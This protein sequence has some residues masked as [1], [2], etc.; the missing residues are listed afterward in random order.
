MHRNDLLK[1]LGYAA[2]AAA[3]GGCVSSRRVTP[4]ALPRI[5]VKDCEFVNTAT[6]KAFHP[7]GFNY[8]RL[9]QHPRVPTAKWHS[10]FG[11]GHYSHEEAKKMFETSSR[12]G[13]NTTRVFLS[14]F[15]F[16]PVDDGRNLNP[17]VMDNLVD[18]LALAAEYRTYVVLT[19]CYQLPSTYY[20][21][22]GKQDNNAQGWNGHYLNDRTIKNKVAYL[23]QLAQEIKDR[24]PRLLSTV[25][26]FDLD[27]EVQFTMTHEPFKSGGQFK[28]LGETYDLDQ[29][30]EI[31]KLMDVSMTNWIDLCSDAVKAVD[32]QAMVSASVFSFYNI[33]RT[34]GPG[35]AREQKSERALRD[36]RIPA[37]PVAIA[38]SK[39]DYIDL[40]TYIG[41]GTNT[42][43]EL[44]YSA[45]LYFH[46][47]EYNDLVDVCTKNGKPL[48]AGEFG[49]VKAST[50]VPEEAGRLIVQQV[51]LLAEHGFAGYLL[52]TFDGHASGAPWQKENWWPGTAQ[53][54]TILKMMSANL[55]ATP[56]TDLESVEEL[57]SYDY[58][59]DA[60]FVEP[61]GESLE[62][63]TVN[64][65][66]PMPARVDGNVI[67]PPETHKKARFRVEVAA[68]SRELGS[69]GEGLYSTW[70]N[71][72]AGI[73]VRVGD[74][75]LG[76][77]SVI[78]G[79]Y[80]HQETAPEKVK[81]SGEWNQDYWTTPGKGKS[82]V[83]KTSRLGKSEY[84]VYVYVGDDPN[85]DHATKAVYKLEYGKKQHWFAV[86]QRTQTNRWVHV[87]RFPFAGRATVALF[88]TEKT[89]N[90]IADSVAFRPA[91]EAPVGD[92]KYR[93][94]VFFPAEANKRPFNMTVNG[95]DLGAVDLA[96]LTN[97]DGHTAVVEE[98]VP[99][100]D[101]VAIEFPGG[102]KPS[103]SAVQ[104]QKE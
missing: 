93:V 56:W 24:D 67:F 39:A 68:G 62:D 100:S 22:L 33:G 71:E 103:V 102:A 36:M 48:L 86:D 28:F 30:S 37:R 95:K 3:V 76:P 90:Y 17:E 73:K 29:S 13:F 55:P 75:S 101:E 63:L 84:D 23:G 38:K 7:I 18:F 59:C 9:Q 20:E 32:L 89:G 25:L 83:W 15:N 91:T 45:R 54:D 97:I 44:D 57:A 16:V 99:T 96:K 47:I 40:H 80:H 78:V 79:G 34:S 2:A 12:H 92:R 64:L 81:L 19:T 58:F 85:K 14:H 53:D 70:C 26:A 66:A 10:P 1:A 74:V 82:A 50:K 35:H 94:R 46:S 104:F 4:G 21:S 51:N 52:W 41:H 27:N 6:G 31:Q 88:C 11:V 8:I 98:V 43:A 42:A 69:L 65:G 60:Q 87:G 49:V 61:E 72:V 5:S 77:N